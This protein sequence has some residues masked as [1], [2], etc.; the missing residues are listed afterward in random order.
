VQGLA[1]MQAMLPACAVEMLLPDAF[2]SASRQTDREVRPYSLKGGIAFLQ[3]SFNLDASALKVVLAPFQE[4]DLMEFRISFS[5]DDSGD[6]VHG[7]V[8][9]LLEAEVDPAATATEIESVLRAAGVTDILTLDQTFPF[10]YCDDC[11]SPLFPNA[12]GEAVHAEL[13]EEGESAPSH[14][15]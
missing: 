5:L 4:H 9:P 7:V 10:E 3:T 11:G 6:V 1:A 15:H 2:F 14:L 8:W 13:P 12:S